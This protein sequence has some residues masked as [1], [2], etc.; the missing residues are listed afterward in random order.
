M[1]LLLEYFFL[2]KIKSAEKLPATP[3]INKH[4]TT[5]S[6]RLLPAAIFVDKLCIAGKPV[7]LEFKSIARKIVFAPRFQALHFSAFHYKLTD[8]VKFV[9]F[10]LKQKFLTTSI[11]IP[12]IC[13][14]RRPSCFVDS[15]VD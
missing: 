6:R 5:M 14:D 10:F 7:T 13:P 1:Y 15:L 8:S 11:L 9:H 12:S 2:S 3:T 4:K